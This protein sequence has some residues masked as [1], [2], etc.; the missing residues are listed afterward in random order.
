MEYKIGEAVLDENTMVVKNHYG[1]WES[2]NNGEPWQ[3][4]TG[5]PKRLNESEIVD[6]LLKNGYHAF[7]GELG[8]IEPNTYNNGYIT[9][10]KN[11]DTED[12]YLFGRGT[13][14]TK[15]ARN[16]GMATLDADRAV[17]AL[18]IALEYEK[19]QQ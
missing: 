17:S 19:I 9:I 11:Q 13:T 10:G 15:N 7:I 2:I 1:D 3:L 5:N 8:E 6:W 16:L 12:W 4:F 18:N 14:T